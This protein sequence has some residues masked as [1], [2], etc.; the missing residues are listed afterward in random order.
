VRALTM[1]RTGRETM[2]STLSRPA[3]TD[4]APPL[5][6]PMAV[7]AS[8]LPWVAAGSLW[9]LLF[10]Y[11]GMDHDALLYAF[12]ALGRM[13]PDLYANDIFLRFGSQDNYTLFSPLFA[14]A[15][16]AFGLEPAAALLTLIS[17]VALFASCWLLARAIGPAKYSVLALGLVIALPSDYGPSSV[18]HYIEG[19]LTPRL[20]AEAFSIAGVALA[21]NQRAVAATALLALGFLVHPVMTAPAIA[22]AGYLLLGE[23]RPRLFAALAAALLVGIAVL[24]LALPED[25]SWKLAG[26]WLQMVNLH[27]PYVF[28]FNWTAE[29]WNGPVTTV[30][31]LGIGLLALEKGTARK[32]CIAS[33]FSVG[34]CLA[35]NLL[36]ADLLRI[37]ILTQAQGYRCLWIAGVVCVLVLPSICI[38]LWQRGRLGRATLFMLAAAWLLRDEMYSLAVAPLTLLVAWLATRKGDE[39]PS[40]PIVYFTSCAVLGFAIVVT[41]ANTLLESSST[42]LDTAAPEIVDRIHTFLDVRLLPVTLL[43]AAWFASQRLRTTGGLVAVVMATAAIGAAMVPYS[44]ADWT[45]SDYGAQTRKAFASWR[46]EIPVGEDVAWLDRPFATWVLL[47][48]PSYYSTV[49]TGTALFSRKA[50]EVLHNRKHRVLTELI[51]APKS[52]PIKK[53]S[54]ASLAG[55]CERYE[56]RFIVSATDLHPTSYVPAPAGVSNAY[57]RFRLYQCP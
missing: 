18:F 38:N 28:L 39:E 4:G 9:L 2:T 10:N 8:L 16:S 22:V 12:Q 19:F 54:A 32:V 37:S 13:R 46:A 5:A 47:E 50:A 57:R 6:Q 23:S 24:G 44:V 40:L 31:T 49:Q 15:I 27:A 20:L 51:G 34:F 3:M 42:Y 26:T 11:R 55:L 30:A 43:L 1:Q 53:A 35:L 33:L 48:R 52:A 45:R 29:D 41:T 25:S 17:T 7:L 14:S 56:T 21:L 36:G